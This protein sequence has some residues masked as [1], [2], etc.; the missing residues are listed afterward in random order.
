M[1]IAVAVFVGKADKLID[2]IIAKA[3]TLVVGSGDTKDVDIAPV[4]YKGLHENILNLIGTVKK[5]GGKVL[6]DGTK[7]KHPTLPQGNFIGPTV[8]EV[9][10]N[11]TAY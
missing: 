2:T 10:E 5:E 11:M 4:C 8:L 1:A 3:N 7:F 9:G 6:L